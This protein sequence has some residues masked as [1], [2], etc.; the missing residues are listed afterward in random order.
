M[1]LVALGLGVSVLIDATLI[2]LV[3]VPCAMFL[4]GDG[5]WWLP[6]WLDRILPHLEPAP[7]PPAAAV[8]A[9][10]A[11]PVEPSADELTA[12]A[13]GADEEASPQAKG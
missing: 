4:L 1:W 10:P 11:A 9:T 13:G 5:N 6:G 12:S 8:T 7:E 3:V 2:R